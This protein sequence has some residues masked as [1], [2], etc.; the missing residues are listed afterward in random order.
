MFKKTIQALY[1]Y[2]FAVL[3]FIILGFFLGYFVTDFVVNNNFTYYQ[4]EITATENPSEYFTKDFFSQQEKLI[5][6]YNYEVIEYNKNIANGITEG[7]K[8]STIYLPSNTSLGEISN[9]VKIQKIND[10]SYLI[11]IARKTFSNTFVSKTMKVSEGITKCQK[12]MMSIF[13]S[14]VDSIECEVITIVSDFSMSNYFNP[15]IYGGITSLVFLFINILFVFFGVKKNIE[16]KNIYDNELVFRTPFHKKYW[17]SAT[18][19]FKKVSNLT[20][21]AVLFAIMMACKAITLP[22]GFGAL[23]IS[24]TYL[25][26]SIIACLYGPIAG[27]VIGFLS[28]T[29]GFFIFPNG[30]AFFLGYTL[31]AMLAGFTY[32]IAFYKTK[33]TFAK[34]LY[35][36]IFVNLIVNAIL[37]SIWWSIINS[38][39]FDAFVTY[40]LVISF[41]KNLIYLLPQSILLFIVLKAVARPAAQFNLIEQSVRDNIA[42]I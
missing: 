19:C 16:I 33:I 1:K 13:D 24:F 21:I 35:A 6:E 4:F 27:L 30:Q 23:G 32:G 18:Q 20:I 25:F 26:F 22:S 2:K 28:D 8:K 14:Q 40:T 7:E 10:S 36:R 34:C 17:V 5:K 11:K 12:T 9:K 39:T 41:P 3:L 15:F 42:I 31:D 38:F 37:G 29:L